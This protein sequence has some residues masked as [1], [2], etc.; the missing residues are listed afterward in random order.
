M[1]EDELWDFPL[2]VTV[3]EYVEYMSVWTKG[4]I[5]SIIMSLEIW[6]KRVER[7]KLLRNILKYLYEL[8]SLTLT[9]HL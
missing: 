5:M 6:R 1:L 4:I 7:K 2:G 8:G 9:F 3:C